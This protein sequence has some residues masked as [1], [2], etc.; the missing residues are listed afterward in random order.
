MRRRESATAL[1]NHRSGRFYRDGETLTSAAIAA[2][3]S[4]RVD[5]PTNRS[6]DPDN[7]TRADGNHADRH[8][9]IILV[10]LIKSIEIV[11]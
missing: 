8:S 1:A 11:A 3:C 4:M 10:H 6:D 7:A 5:P 9:L 2:P